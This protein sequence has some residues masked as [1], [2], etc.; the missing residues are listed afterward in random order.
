LLRLFVA[1]ELPDPIRAAIAGLASGLRDR[2]R[3]RTLRWS[4]PEQYHL[5]LK[6][7]GATG[8]DLVPKIG[9]RLEAAVRGRTPISLRLGR[10]GSFGEG[11]RLRNAWLGLAGEVDLLKR[12]AVDVEG[13]LE[14][15][16]F[17][18][19]ARPFSPHLTFVRT[20]RE[21][22][23]AVARA[24]HEALS[25]VSGGEGAEFR[26]E[27]IVL[28]ESILRP[29]GSLYRVTSAFPLRG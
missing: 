27:R 12:L 8:E 19:E 25:S 9:E 26:V 17:P 16:G 18:P 2:I 7:L 4:K 29:E 24:L 5:T 23:P 21:T 10:A 6:F 13:A 15:L 14:P 3:D 11:K 1:V 20:R 28:M 22:P